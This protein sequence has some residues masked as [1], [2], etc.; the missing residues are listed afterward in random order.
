MALDDV[1]VYFLL[2]SG[3]VA[4]NQ[5][6]PWYGQSPMVYSDVKCIGWEN[7]LEECPKKEFLEFSCSES[8][9]AGALCAYC[10]PLY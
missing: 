2:N 9:V 3:I 6:Y 8:M 5:L 7:S 1:C 10:E 4:F